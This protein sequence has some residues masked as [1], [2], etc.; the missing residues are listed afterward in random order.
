MDIQYAY[1]GTCEDIQNSEK[2]ITILATT[3]ATIDSI[4]TALG[5]GDKVH[6]TD[7]YDGTADSTSAYPTA[8]IE[9]RLDSLENP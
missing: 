2:T 4:I 8:S 5:I 9:E 1:K 3:K 6:A 7:L